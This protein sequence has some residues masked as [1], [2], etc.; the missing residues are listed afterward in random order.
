MHTPQK[1]HTLLMARQGGATQQAAPPPAAVS[2]GHLRRKERARRLPA[3]SAPA[4]SAALL[5]RDQQVR[6]VC[7]DVHHQQVSR[8]DDHRQPQR[9]VQVEV[10][11]DGAWGRRGEGVGG[12]RVKGNGAG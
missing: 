8:Q 12:T 9:L 5:A 4:R 1:L 3:C 2:P 6:A 11:Q 10:V 7:E